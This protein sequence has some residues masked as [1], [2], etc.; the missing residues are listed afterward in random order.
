MIE[1]HEANDAHYAWML[2]ESAPPPG[3]PGLPDGGVAENFILQILRDLAARVSLEYTPASWMM[4]EKGKLV[5]LLSYK[6][7]PTDAGAVEIG[8]GVAPSEMGRGV[9]TQAVAALLLRAG[10][11]GLRTILAETSGDN[12]AS[13]RVLER[14]GF[15]RTGTRVDPEDGP[16]IMWRREVA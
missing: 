11:Q 8:Y 14:N 9:A 6:G 13:Q 5:G 2:G 3:A 15:I 7:A 1:L 10:E 4:V 12:P 16:L